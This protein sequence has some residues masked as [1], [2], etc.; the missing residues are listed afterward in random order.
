MANGAV[1]RVPT[2]QKI[3]ES[4]LDLNT[5]GSSHKVK[6]FFLLYH[7]TS[8]MPV[9]KLLSFSQELLDA[10]HFF[11][12]TA[13]LP[14]VVEI[15]CGQTQTDCSSNSTNGGNT[16]GESKDRNTCPGP[17]SKTTT[18]KGPSCTQEDSSNAPVPS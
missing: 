9:T 10:I 2:K 3:C 18:K 16:C 7:L 6:K 13:N 15:S 12:G 11:E 1:P 4:L 8:T 14:Q 17:Q 5:R